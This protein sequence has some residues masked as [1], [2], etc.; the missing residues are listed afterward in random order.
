MQ[1]FNEVPLIA[2]AGELWEQATQAEFLTAAGDGTLPPEAFHR[3][4]EQ[5]YQ[6]A[7]RLVSFQA[8]LTAK[9]PRPAHKL[10]IAGLSAID[11]ELDWFERHLADRGLAADATPHPAC[12]R[13]V[14]FLLTAAYAE[15]FEVSLAVLFGVEV[16]YLVAW[17]QLAASGPYAEFITRWSNDGF[18]EYVRSLRRLVDRHPHP[19]QAEAFIATLCHERDF[20]RMT[21]EG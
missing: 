16:C 14:D 1:E 21:W 15:P 18:V 8:V 13:Y 20:W 7:R 2:A 6:F 4:L 10:L 19:G 11:A 5:D 9:T 12:R 17:S 3:W